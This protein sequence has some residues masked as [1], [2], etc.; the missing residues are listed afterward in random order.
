MTKFISLFFAA[1]F[2]FSCTES[3]KPD[4]ITTAPAPQSVPEQTSTPV[5]F[6]LFAKYDCKTCHM[7]DEKL[8]GPSYKEIAAKYAGDKTAAKYLAG[9][10]INGGSGVWGE[11]PMNPHPGMPADDANQLAEYIIS[12]K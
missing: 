2:L 9:K 7:A 1:V 5:D 10:I 11:I 4:D 6:P 12:L 8:I 3:N